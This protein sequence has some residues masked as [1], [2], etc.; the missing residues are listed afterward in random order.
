LPVACCLLPVACCLLP[1]ACCLLPVA[2][3]LLPVA[4]RDEAKLPLKAIAPSTKG[5][6][7]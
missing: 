2:C 4:L 6:H 1:V 3:C 5:R 7:C